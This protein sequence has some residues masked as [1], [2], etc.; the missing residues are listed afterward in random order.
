M[1]AQLLIS[2]KGLFAQR[3]LYNVVRELKRQR[4]ATGRPPSLSAL[5]QAA[6][7]LF[8]LR[9]NL[10]DRVLEA[11]FGIDHVTASRAFNRALACL[12]KIR[13]PLPAATPAWYAVDTTTLRIGKGKQRGHFTG[14]KHLSGIKPQVVVTDRKEVVDVSPAHPASAHDYRIFVREWHRLAQKLDRACPYWPTRPMSAC[15]A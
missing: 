14:Y 4:P 15:T 3:T 1:S 12:N 2:V 9:Y 6:L 10:P 8:K 13:A 5:E 11:L 7:F